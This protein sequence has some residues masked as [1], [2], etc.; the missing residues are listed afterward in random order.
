MTIADRRNI[1]GMTDKEI[2]A[3]FRLKWARIKRA[4]AKQRKKE[5]L[6]ARIGNT[7]KELRVKVGSL[8]RARKEKREH[9]QQHSQD[10]KP[11]FF[12]HVATAA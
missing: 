10:V 4:K 3:Y 6:E 1:E 8:K 5:R 2:K 7:G 9:S 11:L 12:P